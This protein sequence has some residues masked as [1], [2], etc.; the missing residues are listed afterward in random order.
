MLGLSSISAIRKSRGVDARQRS[1]MTQRKLALQ[2]LVCLLILRGLVAEGETRTAR[3]G[4]PAQ[5]LTALAFIAAKEKGYYR[6][7][8][9][10]AELIL[11][12]AP[13]AT[14]AV[15]GGDVQFSIAA[16]SALNSAVRG[17]PLRFLFHTYYRPLYWLYAKPDIRDVAG[18]KG[19]KVGISGIGSGPYFLLL[20][21]LKRHGLEGGRDVA[22][23]TTGV[24]SSSYAALVSGVVDA[25]S[26][27]PPFMFRAEEAGFRELV[28]FVNQDL[29][30]LQSAIILREGLLQTD[31]IL[32]EK[33][34][35]G[36]LKG[37]FYARDNRSGTIPIITRLLKVKEDTAAKTYDLYRSAMTPDGTVSRELQK[38]FLE[39]IVKRM[40]LKEPPPLERLFDYSL[41]QRIRSELE[42]QGWKPKE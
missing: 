23:L 16:G 5:N 11:M 40:R 12:S 37:F 30:E 35:R 3:V 42:A 38:K 15:I 33:F 10:D 7:E 4:L 6:E 9:I 20:E 22:I 2:I 29:I 14:L 8:G 28:S 19:K 1:F 26:L 27:T 24:Q 36:T 17:A 34:V 21:I 39:D 41:V 18:L 25:T 31:P 13:V 32:V